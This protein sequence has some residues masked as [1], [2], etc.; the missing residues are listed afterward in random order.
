M[1]APAEFFTI[2]LSVFLFLVAATALGEGLRKRFDADGRNALIETL[3]ARVNAWW[4]MAI[5]LTLTIIIGRGA[6][7]VLF[8]VISFAA[9]REF[10]TLTR[11]AK[12]DHWALLASFFVILPVQY[13]SIWMNWYGFYAIFIPVYAFL[14]LPVLSVMRGDT[15]GFLARVSETQW[16]LMITVFAGSHVPALLWL[17]IPGYGGKDMML[18]FFLILVVQGSEI[19]QYVFGHFFGRTKI[20]KNIERSRTWEGAIGGVVSGVIIAALLSWAM[21]FGTVGAL[22]LGLLLALFGFFGSTVMR[23]IKRDRGVHD[24]G[25]VIPGQGGFIDR[26]DSL[27]FA[28]PMFFHLVRFFYAA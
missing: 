19:M 21:P 1:S 6:V 5:G 24:W 16:A 4:A 25:D 13:V 28:A 15:K 14:F 8:A 2:V 18:I 26:L 17:D 9:L 3:L 7:V 12:A 27:L 22:T 10:L 20:N 11:K 23:A